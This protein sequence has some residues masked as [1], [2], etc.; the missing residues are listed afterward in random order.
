MQQA[1]IGGPWFYHP[2]MRLL[3]GDTAGYRR[4][5]EAL[6]ERFD[7][8]GDTFNFVR[9]GSMSPD[10]AVEPA[11]LTQ[12]VEKLNGLM[13]R[14][15]PAYCRGVARYRAGRFEEALTAL[16]EQENEVPPVPGDG[17]PPPRPLGGGP[18]LAA[19][20][21]CVVRA[22]PAPGM[23]GNALSCP[24]LG[25]E[26]LALFEILYREAGTLIDGHAPPVHPLVRLHRARVYAWLGDAEKAEA[27]LQ[28]AVD[29]RPEDPAVYLA[30]G[31]VLLQ[32]GHRERAEADFAR[33]L[34]LKTDD[35]YPW[36]AQGRFLAERGRHAEADSA[37]A[38]T[39]ERTPGEPQCLPRP[40]ARGLGHPFPDYGTRYDCC[41][42]RRPD[43]AGPASPRVRRWAEELT[44]RS[45]ATSH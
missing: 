23:A 7:L 6:R 39:A 26:P 37:F 15:W 9:C 8:T 20:G 34:T 2:M 3:T 27:E 18:P 30:T 35:P 41:R 14:L 13:D 10:S 25:G 42:P 21:R 11:R 28:A 1:S 31:R 5:T 40:P 29:A 12:A 32:L 22:A 43:P 19:R 36:I 33:A 24:R 44:W 17:E 4:Y 45:P 16:N 38:R